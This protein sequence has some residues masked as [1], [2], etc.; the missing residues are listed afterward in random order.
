MP[1]GSTS[2]SPGFSRSSVAASVSPAGS[3][4]GMSL[5][6][7]TAMSTVPASSASSISL[8]NSPLPPAVAQGHVGQPIPGGLDLDDL[9][10]DAAALG[11][12]RRDRA[13]LHQRELAAARADFSGRL[14]RALPTSV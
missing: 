5:L 10:P 11:Q 6:L 3:A 4:A 8:T 13:S 14:T 9:A 2:A 7:C 12:Q 1:A